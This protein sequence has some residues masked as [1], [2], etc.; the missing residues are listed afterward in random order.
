MQSADNFSQ[1]GILEKP[2]R[3]GNSS[4]APQESLQLNG[5][6]NLPTFSMPKNLYND[7]ERDI[8]MQ[9][10]PNVTA[11]SRVNT[12]EY[13]K[14]QILKSFGGPGKPEEIDF[15]KATRQL[16]K[17]VRHWLGLRQDCEDLL[18][19]LQFLQKTYNLIKGKRGMGW[20]YDYGVDAGESFEALI[21]QC[22]IC[23]R[24]TQVY[25]D[26]TNIRI[27]LVSAGTHSQ[28]YAS[29]LTLCASSF[30]LQ[31]NAWLS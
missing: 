3:G 22:D 10:G 9:A 4:E 12:E 14:R 13:W 25:H 5:N 30:T 20:I 19:Q 23:V 18:A 17:M 31:I 7:E 28:D 1:E 15:D 8:G 16:H 11:P 26:R 6:A 21:S 29:R 2:S 24:W 27:Q